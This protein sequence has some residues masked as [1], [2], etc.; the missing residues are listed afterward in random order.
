LPRAVSL[1]AKIKAAKGPDVEVETVKGDRGAFEVFRDGQR[2][3]SKLS[4]GRFPT[5]EDEVVKLL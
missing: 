2:V 5:S 1:A 3:F 4:A